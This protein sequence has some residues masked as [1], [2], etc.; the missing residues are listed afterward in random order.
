[1]TIA[2]NMKQCLST[3]KNIEAELSSL[4]LNS[5]DEEAKR[6]FHETMLLMGETK[7]DLQN[8]VYEIER[9]EPQYK[10]S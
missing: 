7:N 5:S 2:S 1:M 9:A 10:G 8:R 4:A 3:V 6:I